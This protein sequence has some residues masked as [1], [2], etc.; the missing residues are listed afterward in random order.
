MRKITLLGL[1]LGLVFSSFGQIELI[2][3]DTIDLHCYS[4]LNGV[5]TYI[6]SDWNSNK[7]NYY[8]ENLELIKIQ[9]LPIISNFDMTCDY[10]SRGVLEMGEQDEWTFTNSIYNLDDRIEFIYI[11][12]CRKDTI[13]VNY[14]HIM[15]EDGD[16]LFT[17]TTE[18][19]WLYLQFVGDLLVI[20]SEDSQI[21]EKKYVKLPGNVNN[22]YG[23][24]N[25]S[26]ETISVEDT[27][28]VDLVTSVG[29]VSQNEL[30]V[31]NDNNTIHYQVD[32]AGDFQVL[33][34]NTNA[35]LQHQEDNFTGT[36]GSF[37][38]SGLASGMY[39]ITINDNDEVLRSETK[40]IVIR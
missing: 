32:E 7:I 23:M 27:L 21:K 20:G 37:D 25:P 11:E 31:W 12:H 3:K 30:R 6:G 26:T 1:V 33:I 15:N 28:N 40:K 39:F 38:A 2:K 24:N 16:V 19:R 29:E 17:D 5:T 22:I 18:F 34:F 9:E 8:D 35:Q 36:N 14:L 10:E 13:R 4:T